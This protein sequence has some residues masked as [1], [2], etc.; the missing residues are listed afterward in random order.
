MSRAVR[1]NGAEMPATYF[2]NQIKIFHLHFASL[3]VSLKIQYQDYKG[4]I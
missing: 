4:P 2:E 1:I 3:Y